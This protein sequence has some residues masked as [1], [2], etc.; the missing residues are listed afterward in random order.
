[1]WGPLVLLG[2]ISYSLY[3]LHTIVVIWYISHPGWF[4][5]IPGWLLYPA[6]W[7]FILVASYLGWRCI[8]R[9][10]RRQIL[11]WWDR[12]SAHAAATERASSTTAV[13]APPS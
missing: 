3:L 1:G 10:C 11:A 8:E 7:A 6:F 12:R 5:F 4:T 13:V 9:P 2:E